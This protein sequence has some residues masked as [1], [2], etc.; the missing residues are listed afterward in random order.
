MPPSLKTAKAKRDPMFGAFRSNFLTGLVV[1]LPIGLTLYFVWAFIGWIDGWILPLIPAAYQPEA[2][3]DR[4][5]GPNF[6]FPVRGI[7]AL[8]FLFFTAITGW[9]ARGLIGKRMV[10]VWCMMARSMV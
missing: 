5:I 1:V 10:R 3:V 8:V 2:L 7:G 4:F 9:I 6:P